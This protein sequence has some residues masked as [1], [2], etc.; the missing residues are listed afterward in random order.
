MARGGSSPLGRTFENPAPAGF[1]RD[2]GTPR[3]AITESHDLARAV[4]EQ[5]LA[6]AGLSAFVRPA[7]VNG[8][9]GVVVARRGPPFSVMGFTVRRGRIVEVD[10]LVDPARL[11]QLEFHAL[12]D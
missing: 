7:L 6:F 11:Q 4:A 1:F 9:A 3:G 10:I 2:S 12:D 8:A 5:A